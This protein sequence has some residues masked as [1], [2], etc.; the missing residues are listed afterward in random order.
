M[1]KYKIIIMIIFNSALHKKTTGN[2]KIA[3]NKKCNKIAKA[4]KIAKQK[5]NIVEIKHKT[6]E[7]ENCNVS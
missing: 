4:K 3:K 5:R 7:K 2:E 6:L 1:G